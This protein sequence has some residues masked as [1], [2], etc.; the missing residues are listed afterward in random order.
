MSISGLPF[1]D[2]RLLFDNLAG[3]DE[4]AVEKVIQ[5]NQVLF[6]RPTGDIGKIQEWLA[7]WSGVSPVVSRPLVAVFAGTHRGYE[8]A[9]E[10]AVLERVTRLA[11]GGAPLNQICALYDLG[12]K[13]FDLALQYPVEDISQADALDEKSAAGT[14]AFGMEAIAGGV[15]LLVLADCNSNASPTPAAVF[16]ALY[17]EEEKWSKSAEV[18]QIATKAVA[19]HKSISGDGLELLRRLGGRE[20]W[21]MAGAIMAARVEHV[22]VILDGPGPLSAAAVLKACN[23]DSIAHC[24][25][26]QAGTE[27]IIGSMIE[28]LGI[29]PILPITIDMDEGEGAALAAGFVKAAALMHSGVE[30]IGNKLTN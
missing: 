13:V 8:G 24:L 23:P 20:S 3:P 12:L 11:A 2:I 15:D 27:S 19:R 14:F 25:A 1:D 9:G 29:K 18:L 30:P 21:A 4:Q 7:R 17:G 22:P 28:A 10:Q 16:G 6:G 26:G 5:R